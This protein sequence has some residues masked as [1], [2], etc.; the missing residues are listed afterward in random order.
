M[1]SQQSDGH[2]EPFTDLSFD[3]P[4]AYS[5]N[6]LL[7]TKLQNGKLDTIEDWYYWYSNK[8]TKTLMAHQLPE[9]YS[10]KCIKKIKPYNT[11]QQV[12]YLYDP[13]IAANFYYHK[14][15]LSLWN[16]NTGSLIK[17]ITVR[18]E[19]VSHVI[20]LYKQY[21]LVCYFEDR[22]LDVINI[23]NN[24][25]VDQI[26]LDTSEDI[27]KNYILKCFGDRN[28]YMI[29]AVYNFV[30]FYDIFTGSGQLKKTINIRDRA[31][32][33]EIL[34]EGR[35]AVSVY[36]EHLIFEM[37]SGA[38][39]YRLEGFHDLSRFCGLID[40]NKL[41][42]IDEPYWDYR[43]LPFYVPRSR[44]KIINLRTFKVEKEMTLFGVG[45]ARVDVVGPKVMILHDFCMLYFYDLRK[46]IFKRRYLAGAPLRDLK[47]Y[48][49]EPAVIITQSHDIIVSFRDSIKVFKLI[50]KK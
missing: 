15:H 1:I 45:C 33:L 47:Q 7:K 2:G 6:D 35:F 38:L 21:I 41:L 37:K 24:T 46:F 32:N 3:R 26:P 31:W 27:I 30:Q 40:T 5:M 48:D 16:I 25:I 8:H 20:W 44:G 43:H 36:T 23:D 28:R 39:I 17:T 14:D 50:N 18:H 42:C 13:I 19:V 22:V 4:Y 12:F 49:Q 10:V 29:A 9:K 11:V 34:P